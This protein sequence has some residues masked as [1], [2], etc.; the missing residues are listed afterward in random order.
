MILGVLCVTSPC[1]LGLLYPGFMLMA[2]LGLAL[3]IAAAVNYF[4]NRW[5]SFQTTEKRLKRWLADNKSI[6]KYLFAAQLQQPPPEWK[7]ADIYAYGCERILLVQHDLLVDLFVK[8]G[9]HTQHRALV[10]SMSGYPHYLQPVAE[11]ALQENPQLPILL[12]HDSTLDGLEM[13]VR[14]PT[15]A[16]WLPVGEHPVIDLGI[17]PEDVKRLKQLRPTNPGGRNYEIPVDC[18]LYASL[19]QKVGVAGEQ[20]TP[21]TELLAEPEFEIGGWRFTSSSDSSFG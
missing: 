7:E 11:K 8:N 19:A 9:F 21:M 2:P 5:H 10:M 18:L 3:M 4:Q 12:L 17:T 6:E 15:R 16:A 14:L 20:Q 13:P 1:H